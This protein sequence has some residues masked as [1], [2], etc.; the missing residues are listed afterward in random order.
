M[1][2]NDNGRMKK[3]LCLV[4]SARFSPTKVENKFGGRKKVRLGKAE[5]I[6][7]LCL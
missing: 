6:S 5:A 7:P 1:L 3:I 4:P 2:T